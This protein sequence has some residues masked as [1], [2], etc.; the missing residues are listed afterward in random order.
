MLGVSLHSTF[1]RYEKH[2]ILVPFQAGGPNQD[3]L[4]NSHSSVVPI[5]QGWYVSRLSPKRPI[6]SQVFLELSLWLSLPL[7][8]EVFSSNK[9]L[10]THDILCPGEPIVSTQRQLIVAPDFMCR[11]CVYSSRYRVRFECCFRSRCQF[12]FRVRMR[13]RCRCCIHMYVLRVRSH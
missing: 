11:W 2:M 3:F 6:V 13:F 10:S 1:N 12:R 8:R 5:S 4:P 9:I 7:K